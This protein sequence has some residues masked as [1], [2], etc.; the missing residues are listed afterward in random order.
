MREVK[1]LSFDLDD[2]LWPVAPAIEAA[3]RAVFEWLKLG[4]P[5][6]IENHSIDSMRAIRMRMAEA[7][8]HRQHDM[9]FLR[10]SALAEQLRSAGYPEE[11]AED[12]FE[13]FFAV[14]NRVQLYPDVE[15]ALRRLRRRYRIFALSN[16]NAD[17]SR[18]GIAAYFD[19]HISAQTAG[20]AKP[21]ARI[22]AELSKAAGADA[23]QIMHIG[24][25]PVADVC[26]A[27]NAGMHAAW[28]RRESR[29][30]PAHLDSPAVTIS[31]LDDLL[32][33]LA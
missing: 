4:F 31:T 22:F 21:D 23:A 3:E 2:T 29:E 24:D 15:P 25:D 5:R 10:R 32:A 33:R 1:V 19:G 17:L 27:V 16:G 30:W 13:I 28:V 7:H 8:P 12:A 14:R 6:A 20:V 26:G 18:C 9:T 11:K